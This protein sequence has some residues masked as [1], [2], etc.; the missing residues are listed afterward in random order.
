MPYTIKV[1]AVD[2]PAVHAYT[3]PSYGILEKFT[4]KTDIK[5]IFDIIPWENYYNKMI[6][7]FDG[8]DNYDIVMVAGHLWLSD[9][10]KKG[11]IVPVEYPYDDEYDKNDI[12]P[13]IMNEMKIGNSTYLY[14]SFCD[15]HIILYRK[16]IVEKVLGYQLKN[17]IT[18]DELIN[19]VKAVHGYNGMKGIALKAHPSEIFLDVLPYIR[20]EGI[21]AFDKDTKKPS[22]YNKKAILAIQ[23]YLSLKKYAPNDTMNYGNDEIREAFQNEKVVFAVTWG[24]QIGF[25]LNNMCKNPLDVGFATFKTPWNVTWSFAINYR[26]NNKDIANKFLHFITS[27][28][29]DRIIGGY[30]GSPVR[31]S[32]YD[33]D[34]K[35]YP[36]YPIH[37]K[38]I[39]DYSSPLPN[40]ENAA[41]K[42]SILYRELYQIFANNK[43]ILIALED[44]ENDINRIS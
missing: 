4:S 21:D 36:W 19:A 2:D 27:K 1:L 42:Y 5:V 13:T 30:A 38:M 24:G 37:L 15:G 28:E 41:Q 39:K 32:T 7:S 9:F 22:F 14:P 31:Q 10:V 43:E 18:T 40:I 6:A 23:K 20:N 16:S 17:V 29:V 33:I 44:A 3:D 12:L 26:S 8:K 35:K 25:V 11:Y 34:S